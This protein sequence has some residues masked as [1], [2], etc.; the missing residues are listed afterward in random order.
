MKATFRVEQLPTP[1]SQP[2]TRLQFLVEWDA[3]KP[4]PYDAGAILQEAMDSALRRLIEDRSRREAARPDWS[5][6]G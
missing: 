4:V 1:L 6:H 3:Q 5:W 2:E